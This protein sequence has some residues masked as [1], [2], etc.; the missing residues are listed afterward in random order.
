MSMNENELKCP[1]CGR[2]MIE[3]SSIDKHHLIPKLKGGKE[4]VLLHKICHRKIHSLFKENE[5]KNQY[6]TIEKLLSNEDIQNFVK[7]VKNK[8][9]EFYVSNFQSN[10][11]KR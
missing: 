6:N 10:K 2:E 4:T 5:L 3:G 8:P 9:P 7:W 1:L 11:R